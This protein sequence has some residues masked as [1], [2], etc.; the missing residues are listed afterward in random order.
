MSAL[1]AGP[2]VAL[3]PIPAF[4][5]LH[6][7]DLKVFLFLAALADDTAH[8]ALPANQIASALAISQRRARYAVATL[9]SHG[10]LHHAGYAQ[11]AGL[12]VT[13]YA[14]ACTAP[15]ATGC[16]AATNCTVPPAAN[17]TAPSFSDAKTAIDTPEPPNLTKCPDGPDP[18]H[19]IAQGLK[20][21][22]E[23]DPNELLGAITAIESIIQQLLADATAKLQQKLTPA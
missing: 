10:L 6:A 21:L 23:R 4:Q 12:R 1:T 22:A 13:R 15:R 18:L 2:V 3:P 20:Q 7:T 16:S 11:C 8:I 17:C 19:A 5:S 14:L 9:Q